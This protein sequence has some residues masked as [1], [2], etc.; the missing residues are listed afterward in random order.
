MSTDTDGLDLLDAAIVGLAAWLVLA[1]I[2]AAAAAAA[3]AAWRLL[4]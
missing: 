2:V 3:Y 1:A 4:R